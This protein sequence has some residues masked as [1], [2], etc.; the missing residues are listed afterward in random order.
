MP[1]PPSISARY[2][3]DAAHYGGGKAF[4]V[5]R[6]AIAA[7]WQAAMKSGLSNVS[8]QTVEAVADRSTNTI[9]EFGLA[10]SN[11]WPAPGLKYFLRWSMD[12]DGNPWLESDIS[13]IAPAASSS[14]FPNVQVNSYSLDR[15]KYPDPKEVVEVSN[16]DLSETYNNKKDYAACAA[17]YT[18]SAVLYSDGSPATPWGESLHTP[19]G[20]TGFWKGAAAANITDIEFITDAAVATTEFTVIH[21]LGRVISSVWP[22][23]K[24]LPYYV[25]WAVSKT[26]GRGKKAEDYKAMLESDISP[27]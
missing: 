22:K 24:G 15:T 27:V 14:A 25:R 11:Q 10:I 26:K 13:P 23:P 19:A 5:G 16:K 2:T 17:F 12:S 3:E 18:P 8:F 9:H 20:I 1:P 6:Q 4:V 21:E 7:T